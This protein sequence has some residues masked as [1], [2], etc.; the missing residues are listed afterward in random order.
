MKAG[1]LKPQ[2]RVIK[3]NNLGTSEERQARATL[4]SG[5]QMPL[6]SMERTA[7]TLEDLAKQDR[8]CAELLSLCVVLL[9]NPHTHSK[10]LP[11]L[12]S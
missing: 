8:R 5:L 7:S 6:K 3:E 9:T 10:G 2:S 12:I 1:K 4:K 11:G